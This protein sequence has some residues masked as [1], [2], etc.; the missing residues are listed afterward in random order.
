[1][2]RTDS[3]DYNEAYIV[4]TIKITV[5]NPNNKLIENAEDLDVIMLMY[6]LL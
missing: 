4:V 6:N 1:M 3:C 5:T 2:L